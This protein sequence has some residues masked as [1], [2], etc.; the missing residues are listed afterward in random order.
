MS[1][2]KMSS[3]LREG[4]RGQIIAL[5]NED[6]SQCK[7][8]DKVSVSKD[9]VQRTLQRFKKTGSFSTRLRSGRSR[10]STQ[11]EDR[12]IKATSLSNR[13]ATAVKIQALLNNTRVKPVS[14]KAVKRRLA[15]NGLNGRVAVSK[16]LLQSQN[17]RKR[18]LW[19]GTCK[20]Y[21]VDDWKKVLFSD[22]SKVQLYGNSRRLYV[23]RKSN[24]RMLNECVKSTEKHGGGSI[25][26]WECFSYNG[27]GDL[28]RINDIL[29]KEKYHSILQRHAIPSGLKLCGHGFVLQQDSD[30]KHTS[31]LC[32]KYLQRKED[33]DVLVVIDFLPQ[34]PDLYPIEHLWEHLKRDKTK[35]T[36]TSQDTLWHAINVCW[37]NLKPEIIHKRIESMPNRV[38][39]VLK[40]KG[41][42]TKYS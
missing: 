8:A 14:K 26:V 25:Q 4:I 19:A 30:P 27:V 10:V 22:E 40:A 9:A 13:M 23:R 41:G 32:R 29:T 7:I 34:S 18:L 38:S 20:H 2:I 35:Y 33:H 28:Y 21:T 3:D 1:C 24:E 17:K 16:P 31:K 39:A 11:R 42:Y 15:S 5:I 36:I 37:N 6:M 12:Y